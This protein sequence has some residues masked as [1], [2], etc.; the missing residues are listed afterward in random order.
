V[1]DGE[2]CFAALAEFRTCTTKSRPIKTVLWSHAP[3]L[4]STLDRLEIHSRPHDACLISATFKH[5][6]MQSPSLGCVHEAAC[7][8][9]AGGEHHRVLDTLG[10]A[11]SVRFVPAS[12]CHT[13]VSS[14]QHVSLQ[15][16]RILLNP[17]P[18]R[19]FRVSVYLRG[20]RAGFRQKK[21]A[22]VQFHWFVFT[23]CGCLQS[24]PA[25]KAR[26]DS[27]KQRQHRR[28]AAQRH[29]TPRVIDAPPAS[30]AQPSA[31]NRCWQG[32]NLPARRPAAWAKQCQHHAARPAPRSTTQTKEAA[33]A[34]A[35]TAHPREERLKELK[36]CCH[37]QERDEREM[38]EAAATEDDSAMTSAGDR[39][40]RWGLQATRH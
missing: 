22:A 4:S 32:Q 40:L 19:L 18:I 3:A 35:M 9:S 12:T 31:P 21:R 6:N 20:Y 14:M 33:P 27:A 29:T 8:E 26:T 15:H 34:P 37:S 24:L 16:R 28:R 1:H 36:I 25:V 17:G 5:I 11:R 30:Q 7:T 38:T 23:I 39:R 10:G 13:P 2:C